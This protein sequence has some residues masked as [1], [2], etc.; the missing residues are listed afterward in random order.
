MAEALFLIIS[1]AAACR[2]VGDAGAIVCTRVSYCERLVFAFP[3][4]T[5]ER[6][7]VSDMQDYNI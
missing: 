5:A 1:Q 3:S 2:W 6:I 4:L 7:G